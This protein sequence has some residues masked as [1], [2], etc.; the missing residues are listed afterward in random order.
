MPDISSRR[1]SIPLGPSTTPFR[2]L[3]PP[4]PPEPRLSQSRTPCC[5]PMRASTRPRNFRPF[6]QFFSLARSSIPLPCV[7][8]HFSKFSIPTI[9]K[10]LNHREKYRFIDSIRFIPTPSFLLALRLA[11]FFE[12]ISSSK[13]NKTFVSVRDTS[14]NLDFKG[15]TFNT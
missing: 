4:P 3:P 7:F 5:A 8:P 11:N 10:F 12:G 13:R 14:R 9:K 1:C 6:L 15:D 2:P